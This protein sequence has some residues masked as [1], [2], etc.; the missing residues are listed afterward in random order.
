MVLKS[1]A[2][3][4]LENRVL[5]SITPTKSGTT[6][7]FSDTPQEAQLQLTLRVDHGNLEYSTDGTTFSADLDLTT[8]GTQSAL[9]TNLT[10]IS[11]NLVGGHETLSLEDSLT[12]ALLTGSTMLSDTGAASDTVATPGSNDHTWT[13]NSPNLVRLDNNIQLFGIGILGGGG[14]D[15]VFTFTPN[16][17]G[18]TYQ[19]DGGSGGND[20]LD[21]S[22]YTTG[23]TVD[24]S[25]GTAT[26]TGGVAKFAVVDGGSGKDSFTAGAGNETF[27]GGPGDDTYHFNP[28]A[29]EGSD[30]VI[31]SNG[32]DGGIDTL[33]FSAATVALTVDLSSTNQQSIDTAGNLELTLSLT[34]SIEN[35]I[36]GSGNDALTGNAEDN[37]ITAGSGTA[38]LTGGPGDDTYIFTNNFGNDTVVEAAGNDSGQG[39]DT[40]DFSAVTANLTTT[41]N[42]DNTFAVEGGSGTVSASNVENLIG[43]PGSNTLDYSKYG[44]GV[45]V[46]LATGFATDFADVKGFENVV[47]SNYDDT[48]TG[49]SHANSLSGGAGDDTMSGGGGT[50][51]ISGGAGTNTLVETF[52]ADMTL[53]N[54]SLT[55]T[56]FGG[57]ASTVETLSGIELAALTGGSDS[58]TIDASAFTGLTGLTPLSFLN[59]GAGVNIANGPLHIT[60]TTVAL[61]SVDLSSAVSVQDVLHAID[62]ANPQLTATLNVAGTGINL[63]D[64]SGGQGNLAVTS[65]SSL[66]AD[67]GLNVAGVGGMLVGASVPA[68][69]VALSGGTTAPLS[70]LNNGA[71]VHTS[72]L[73]ENNL[74]GLESTTRVSTLNN[75]D[76]VQALNNGQPDFRVILTD[77]T[78]VDVKLTINANSTVQDVLSAISTAANGRLVVELD[79]GTGDA[80]SLMDTH[81]GGSD[82][83]VVALDNSPAA[84]GL[85]ILKIGSGQYLEG[86]V[87]TSVNAD[88]GVTLTDGT[89]VDIDLSGLQTIQDVIAAI[90]AADPRLVATI[91]ATGT[92]LDLTDTAGGTGKLTVTSRNGSTAGSDLGIAG[93][94]TGNVL[95]GTSI[96]GTGALRLDNRLRHDTLFG[97][98]GN[99]TITA[100]GGNATITGGGGI[101]TL[102]ESG[103]A[104]FTLTN[105]TLTVAPFGSGT[106]W[107]ESLSGIDQANLTGGPSGDILDASAFT[108]GSVTLVGGTGNDMVLGGSGN[109]FLTGGGGHDT[110]DGGGGYNTDVETA[111][112]RFVV[113]GTP[114]S[115][116][117]DMG[118]GTDQVVTVS[119]TGTV[120]G[121]TFTLSYDNKQ[122][123]PL[124]FSASASEIQNALQALPNIGT[125]NVSV[126]QTEANGPWEVDFRE[127]LGCEILPVLTAASVNLAGGGVSAV[128][129]TPGATVLNTLTK[130]QAVN[131]TGGASNNV[132]DASGYSGD[133]T[134]YGRGGDDMFTGGSGTNYLDGGTG[135]DTIIATNGGGDTYLGGTGQNELIETRKTDVSFTLSNT[136]LTATGGGQSGSQVDTISGFQ[137][138]KL[139]SGAATN[140]SGVTL[141]ASAFTAVSTATELIDFNGGAGLRTT[142]GIDL[143]MIGISAEVPLYT[144]ND[145]T[146]V[147]SVAGGDFKITLSNGMSVNVSVSRAQTLQDVVNDIQ[148]A[149][150]LLTVGLTSAG[151]ALTLTDSAGGSG[152]ISV[153]ALNNSPAAYDLG[154][155]GTGLNNA[156]TGWP[157]SDG[158]GNLRITLTNGSKV[159]VE[160]T[161][162]TTIQDVLDAIHA[163][164]PDLKASLNAASAIVI[165]DTSGGTGQLSVADLNGGMAAEDLGI[166]GTAAANVLTGSPLA[167]SSVTLAGGAGNDT[168]M[169]GPAND[170]LTGKGGT[171]TLKGGGG[172]DTVVESGDWNLT[173]TNTTLTMI[174]TGGGSDALTGIDQA[175]LTGGSDTTLFDASAFTL[176]PVTMTTMGGLAT[177]K[178]GTGGEN[179]YDLNVAGL[180]AP[181][182]ATDTAHQF[183]VYTGGAS[184]KVVIS[185][186]TSNVTQSDFW[187]AHFPVGN[188]QSYVDSH[189]L[190][191]AEA[192]DPNSLDA[193]I[194]VMSDIVVPDMNITLQAGFI[195]MHG[196]TLSTSGPS[197][198]SITLTGKHIMI[199]QG[200][201]LTAQAT[202]QGL[203][204]ENG[205]ITIQALDP[206]QADAGTAFGQPCG[207]RQ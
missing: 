107:V 53:T 50:D 95:H 70:L 147:Q 168:L 188:A 80:I 41:I 200:A 180:T 186:G 17:A 205:A 170:T 149:S 15:D 38:T 62:S 190:T 105:T 55:V 14:G 118:Q 48:I 102:V 11:V 25:A 183:T 161:T 162:L 192:G 16:A 65:T 81:N 164:S 79:Q 181:A 189:F 106:T 207:E 5:L 143:S 97:T 104:N 172:T 76:G 84:A 24:L 115:A 91:N 127:A 154:I 194:N 33:D 57:A 40:L 73:T 121:G 103:D 68:G 69:H 56:P 169:G 98:Y 122:T 165:T 58:N 167:I 134:M 163:A 2:F 26:D 204:A 156:L 153:S 8:P 3:E 77:G 39:N 23:V 191:D 28:N 174:G 75:G 110:L 71:G 94:G 67:L 1:I 72:D 202:V 114:A 27:N 6:V 45:T 90:D 171:N 137:F 42:N 93:M 78:A 196:H 96:V 108:G 47:G 155:L 18:S 4:E 166:A 117:L 12:T 129:T 109:D 182:S 20:A 29:K 128:L 64:S 148:A 176:G 82:I 61:V 49:D 160:L 206:R 100:G 173:L 152:N 113:T 197:P 112:A 125:D 140:S 46:D 22:A 19:L 52:D 193:T 111:D 187:W 158:A 44:S 135:N 34:D 199:D 30:T 138:A 7:T 88:I 195:N 184:N 101:D 201:T 59:N 151:D 131:L 142:D 133:V 175:Q 136:R 145:N 124:D 99:D 32:T 123:D 132:M 130:I 116:T 150:P 178:G 13:L 10:S 198:G 177:L 63:A 36:G 144:L 139:T 146:G 51:T 66:A 35:V 83:Q 86:T 74:L 37:T 9:L 89:Q 31:E 54:S 60:L 157:I 87:I 159:D 21:Y 126:I 185:G 85:G 92:G 119:L 141:D 179:D 43:G 203:G 120:T